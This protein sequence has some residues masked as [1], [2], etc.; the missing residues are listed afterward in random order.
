MSSG[1]RIILYI[2]RRDVRLSD[3]PAFHCAAQHLK[4]LKNKRS[5]PTDDGRGRD[6][7]LT[8]EHGGAPFTHLL[9]VYVFPA[10]Q[11][12][13]SGF[14]S[15]ASDRSPYPEARSQ[16]AKLWRTGPH[17]AKFIGEGV[18]D[19][20]QKL[21]GLQCG[22]GL[23]MRVGSIADV[24]RDFLEF[25]AEKGCKGG[26]QPQ[27]TG[28]WLTDDDGTEEKDDERTLKNLAAKHD[29]A[30]KVWEDEKF[31]IDECVIPAF[32]WPLVWHCEIIC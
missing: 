12:E 19:L 11:I 6:D 17:R 24:A 8:S 2:L 26:K 21:E 25:Y 30:F 13:S 20:K 28:I 14:L 22:S 23:E 4:R 27:I 32:I 5:S 31:Y 10:N 16:V 1:P 18:W 7:S 15:S 29:V 3:N 9:P